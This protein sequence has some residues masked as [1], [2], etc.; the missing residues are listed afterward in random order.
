MSNQKDGGL[1]RRPPAPPL[2][3]VGE[4]PPVPPEIY[5]TPPN[6]EKRVPLGRERLGNM[7]TGSSNNGPA[8]GTGVDY[9]PRR[10]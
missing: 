7:Y 3:S 6:G 9:P 10:K 1:R 5:G 2:R 8:P 4:L